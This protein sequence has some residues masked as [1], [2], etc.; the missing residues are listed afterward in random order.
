[1]QPG[2]ISLLGV[3]SDS[4]PNDSDKLTTELNGPHFTE[5][6]RPNLTLDLEIHQHLGSLK[7]VIN[8]IMWIRDTGCYNDTPLYF[9]DDIGIVFGPP[10]D[11]PSRFLRG[12]LFDSHHERWPLMGSRVLCCQV[13][14][15]KGYID[16]NFCD[17]LGYG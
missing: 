1:M 5:F 10:T 9:T 14:T 8:I 2:E 4:A 3:W 13:V 11:Y 6:G 16:S 17:T 12:R 15:L 7:Y